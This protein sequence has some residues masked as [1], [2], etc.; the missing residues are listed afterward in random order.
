MTA[1]RH[2][3]FARTA[4]ADDADDLPGSIAKLAAAG[5]SVERCSPRNAT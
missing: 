5:T 1:Q 4:L 3:R 2:Q